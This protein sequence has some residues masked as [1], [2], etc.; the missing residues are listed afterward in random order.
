MLKRFLPMRSISRS[1]LAEA[2]ALFDADWYRPGDNTA[3]GQDMLSDYLRDGWKQ[4][5]N[6]N[7]FFDGTWYLRRYRDVADAG[8]NPLIHFLQYGAKEYRSPHPLFDTKWYLSRYPTA[9][10]SGLNPLLY[11]LQTGWRN[12]HSPHPLLDI[13]RYLAAHVDV[14][15]AGCNPAIHYIQRGWI[16]GRNPS[17]LF[18]IQYY[19]SQNPDVAALGTEPLQHWVC[20]GVWNG[21]NPHPL[22]D[23][24]YYIA[25]NNQ[26][27]AAGLNPTV[28]FLED[29]WRRG[30][31]PHPLFDI[32]YYLEQNRDVAEKGINPLVHFIESGAKERRNPNAAFHTSWYVGAYPDVASLENPFLDFLSRQ[33]RQ[34]RNPSP[35]I[36][37][38]AYVSDQPSADWRH[39]HPLTRY[40]LEGELTGMDVG[41][42]ALVRSVGSHISPVRSAPVADGGWEW[43]RHALFARALRD[44]DRERANR[45]GISPFAQITCE[46]G[47]EEE[48]ARTIRFANTDDPVV[49][50]IVPVFNKAALTL[51]CLRSLADNA[52]ETAYEVIVADDGSA[53]PSYEYVA[54]ISGIRFL[55]SEDNRGFL[56]NCNRVAPSARGRFLLF[57]NNDAQARPG[58]LDALVAAHS[59]GVGIVGPK[60]VYPSGHVQEAGGRIAIDGSS[61]LIGYAASPIDARYS[62]PRDVEYISGAC[63][64]IEKT[65][66]EELSGF[67]DCY[68]PAYY[69]DVDLC[70]RV[71]QR[72]LTVRYEPRAEIVHALSVTMQAVSTDFKMRQAATNSQRFVDRWQ[73]QIE[74]NNDV[75]VLAFYLPQYHAIPENDVWW[76]PGF[77]EWSNVAKAVPNYV[78]H[79]QPRVPADLGFYNLTQREAIERQIA[80]AHRYGLSGFC[81]YYYWFDGRR[82]LEKPLDLF[83]SDQSLKID[84]CLCWANE[85]WTRRWDG[86][87]NDILL[88]QSYTEGFERKIVEDLGRY[89]RDSRYIRIDGKPLILV[90]RWDNIPNIREVADRWRSEFRA[91]DLGEIFLAAVDSFDLAWKLE[92]PAD[93]GFD[94]TVGFPPHN[95]G[96]PTAKPVK[97]I[98]DRFDGFVDDYETVALR[99]ATDLPVQV[100]PHFPGV[101]VGWDNT[102]RRQDQPYILDNSTPGAFRAWLEHA[103]EQTRNLNKP[104]ERLVFVNAWNEWG[105]GAYLEPDRRFGHA[106]LSA[107]KAALDNEKFTSKERA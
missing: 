100:S 107:L 10:T 69:E 65:L 47:E 37:L 81:F 19:L 33:G 62:F 70:F 83:L 55:R 41:V 67:D 89:V 66:F 56:R 57:F 78:N 5:S 40:L 12:A 104:E 44:K 11:F 43:A 16:E 97:M 14:S 75:K 82:I 99:Y 96:S 95:M 30:S 32:D 64:L 35:D 76:G 98:N 68:A 54:N 34:V 93:I 4:G 25:N 31:R 7:P 60:I 22:F 92:N 85:N 3:S 17:P 2:R 79:A 28:D 24:P 58:L 80:L 39:E 42:Y 26:V 103:I 74:K 21:R 84:F 45:L 86:R 88:Q 50:V 105:E 36:D 48:F 1:V 101:A 61:V 53:D 46:E 73:A 6:P 49:S 13:P 18:D 8:A 59:S 9:A 63:L 90:Y 77:T 91:A 87:D 20:K 94:A 51:G 106:Y 71:R 52:G 15:L 72:G 102:A 38:I 27:V 23:V 29:G